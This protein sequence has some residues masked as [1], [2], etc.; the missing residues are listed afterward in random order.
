MDNSITIIEAVTL[1]I[2]VLGAA[3]G[4]MNTLLS[5]DRRRVKIS[6]TP[7]QSIAVGG[8]NASDSQLCFDIVN[9]SDFPITVSEIGVLHWWTSS[10]GYIQQYSALPKKLDRRESYSIYVEKNVLD[11]LNGFKAKCVYLKTDCGVM[12]KGSS[13][14]LKQMIKCR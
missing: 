9:Y 10:R 1:S 13:P 6:L 14:A 12:V 11:P 2:A 5:I 7:K 4:V 3:L 8:Y